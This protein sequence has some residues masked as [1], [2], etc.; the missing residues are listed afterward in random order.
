MG[1][2]VPAKHVLKASAKCVAAATVMILATAA[3]AAM[4]AQQAT[5]PRPASR[6]V[7]PEAIAFDDHQ[8]VGRRSSMA[9]R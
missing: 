8:G 5:P 9:R 3:P 1:S 4:M 6:F 2:H 7:H